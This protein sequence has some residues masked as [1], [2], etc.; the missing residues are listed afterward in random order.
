M[1]H[2][3][4]IGQLKAE[5]KAHINTAEIQRGVKHGVLLQGVFHTSK[6]VQSFT[7][8][9]VGQLKSAVIAVVCDSHAT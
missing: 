1:T 9:F 7:P 3:L 6:Y 8:S 2:P 5:F 4:L